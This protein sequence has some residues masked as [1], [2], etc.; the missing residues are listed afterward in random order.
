VE[1][2]NFFEKLVTECLGLG[3]LVGVYTSKSQ[4]DP[5]MGDSYSY[6][7]NKG[8]ALWYAHYDNTPSFYDFVPFGGW[9]TPFAKQYAG[10]VATCGADVDKNWVA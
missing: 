2:N 10:D 1:I 6:A 5:I 3:M 4:W 9:T 8:L 7:A